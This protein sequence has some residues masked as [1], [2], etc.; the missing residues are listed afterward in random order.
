MRVL[1]DVVVALFTYCQEDYIEDA[2][3]SIYNQTVFPKKLI[4]IDDNSSDNTR[5]VIEKVLKYKPKELEVDVR[6]SSVNRRLI[7]Q[8]NTLKGEFD[9]VLIIFQAGDDIARPNRVENVYNHWISR[10]KPHIIHSSYTDIDKDKNSLGTHLMSLSKQRTLNN[11]IERKII[12]GGCTQVFS[13]DILNRFPPIDTSTFSEDRI[14]MFRGILLGKVST[15]NEVLLDYRVNVGMSYTVRNSNEEILESE[16][17]YLIKELGEIK[18][19]ISDAKCFN[20]KKV[21]YLLK[22]RERY[23]NFVLRKIIDSDFSRK[24][25]LSFFI[26]LVGNVNIRYYSPIFRRRKKFNNLKF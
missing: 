16:R 6:F 2:I 3:A 20:N 1:E 22:L 10:G 19:N 21:I 11:I 23:I 5:G 8:I 18:Q 25:I 9:D 13:S 24:N 14:L 17:G 15:I 4:I 12:L 26:G 7:G